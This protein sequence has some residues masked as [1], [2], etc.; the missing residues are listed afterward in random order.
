MTRIS[1]FSAVVFSILIAAIIL[2]H[3]TTAI[4]QSVTVH[5]LIPQNFVAQGSLGQSMTLQDADTNRNLFPNTHSSLKSSPSDSAAPAPPKHRLQPANMSFMEHYLWDEDGLFRKWGWAAPLTPD[6]RKAELDVRRTMLTAH[7]I[8]GF[9]TEAAM[10][11]AVY[12]GQRTI[13]GDRSANQWHQ[14]LVAATIGAYSITGLLAILSPPPYIRRDNETSTTT[15][16][17]LLAW[18][19]F[20][21]MFVT[22]LLAQFIHRNDYNGIARFHQWSGYITLA[23]L[24]ASLIVVTF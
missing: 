4:A 23:A 16:H 11:G 17:K 7:Q 15:I 8:G 18:V 10:I 2:L 3:H 5:D 13:D 20:T 24:T 9:V 1:S 6:E 21:G 22:P 12:F 14:P 19:H